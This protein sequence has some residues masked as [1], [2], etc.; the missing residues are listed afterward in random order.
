MG[1]PN[2]DSAWYANRRLQMSRILRE[3]P[4]SVARRH[5]LGVAKG[6]IR[7]KQNCPALICGTTQTVLSLFSIP[8]YEHACLDSPMPGTSYGPV[9]PGQMTTLTCARKQGHGCDGE[10]GRFAIDLLLPA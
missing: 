4:R 5:G 10:Q 8:D 3:I 7:G 6:T 9:P 1:W 2:D